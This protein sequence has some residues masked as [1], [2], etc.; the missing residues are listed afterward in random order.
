MYFSQ[1]KT[2]TTSQTLKLVNQL[3][4]LG[5]S[6]PTV[7]GNK[8]SRMETFTF[9]FDVWF[10]AVALNFAVVSGWQHNYISLIAW[11]V[12]VVRQLVKWITELQYPNVTERL[13]KVEI[14]LDRLEVR[15][16]RLE[17]RMDNV[18]GGLKEI[19]NEIKELRKEREE[20]GEGTPR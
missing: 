16:D 5:L 17:V 13:D 12:T 18:E 11:S 8:D 19:L 15:L 1:D 4:V 20:R 14:R 7:E 6:H 10:F 2:M 3:Q 9:V